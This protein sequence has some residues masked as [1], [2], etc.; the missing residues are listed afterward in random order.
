MRMGRVWR[1]EKYPLRGG[2]RGY[3]A[4]LLI[5]GTA[6]AVTG[7]WPGSLIVGLAMIYY[8]ILNLP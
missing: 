2:W 1:S 4:T 5:V 8:G 3:G 7:T 6:V